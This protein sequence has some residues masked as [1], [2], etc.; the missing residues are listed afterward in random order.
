MN[1][2]TI[3]D[4]WG[5]RPGNNKQPFR[6][7]APEAGIGQLRGT[8]EPSPTVEHDQDRATPPPKPREPTDKEW[9]ANNINRLRHLDLKGMVE[10]MFG[11]TMP[12]DK[13]EAM[14]KMA[15]WS[16]ANV[17]SKVPQ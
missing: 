3:P 7:V 12:K 16:A 10:E 2:P 11:E 6:V 9:V 5:L 14:D 17:Y 13:F 1:E 4:Q 8:P 15:V